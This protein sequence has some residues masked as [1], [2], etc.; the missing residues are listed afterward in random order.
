MTGPE[1]VATTTEPEEGVMLTP[2]VAQLMEAG[3]EHTHQVTNRVIDQ[4]E[5]NN[6]R[7]QAALDLVRESIEDACDR[8]WTPN[9]RYLTGLLYPSQEAI[10]ARVKRL[11]EEKR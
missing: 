6:A 1:T 2:F 10:E 5:Y 4:L 11:A 9:P 3:M 7:L 8:P